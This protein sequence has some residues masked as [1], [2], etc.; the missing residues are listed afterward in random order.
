MQC[1]ICGSSAIEWDL[2][3][4][5]NQRVLLGCEDCGYEYRDGENVVWIVAPV[6]DPFW[7]VIWASYTP[8]QVEL[9]DQIWDTIAAEI[10]QQQADQN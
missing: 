5:T 7:A 8:T 4:N 10:R 3:I 2:D 9:Y 1:P 6:K